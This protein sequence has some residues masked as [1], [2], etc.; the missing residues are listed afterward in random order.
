MLCGLVE[1][2]GRD[3]DMIDSGSMVTHVGSDWKITPAL[4]R[5][6]QQEVSRLDSHSEWEIWISCLLSQ[7]L[8]YTRHVRAI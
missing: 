6:C 8:Y 7:R 1:V 5:A 3:N 2:L 4:F